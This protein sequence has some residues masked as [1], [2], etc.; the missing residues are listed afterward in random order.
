MKKKFL[1]NMSISRLRKMEQNEKNPKAKMILL[2]CI[3]KKEGHA[4]KDIAK[5]LNKPYNTV[6]DWIN[7]ISKEGLKR[8]YDIKQKGAECKLDD[9][10]IK[11]LLK[12]LYKGPKATGYESNL[13]TLRLINMYIKKEFNVDYHDESIWQLLRRLGCRPIVPRPHNPKSATPEEREA[14]KKS[15]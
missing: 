6:R 8:R 11:K 13:W 5:M 14:F 15:S 2:A 9:K 10:Q 12:T 1:P 4:L 7:R 3:A